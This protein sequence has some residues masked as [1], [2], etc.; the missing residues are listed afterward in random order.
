[1]SVNIVEIA[2]SK[3]QFLLKEIDDLNNF[4]QIAQVLLSENLKSTDE[5]DPIS[6]ENSIEAPEI[7][8]EDAIEPI[9]ETVMACAPSKGAAP[10][11]NAEASRIKAYL[12]ATL[13]ANS[14]LLNAMRQNLINHDEKALAE[15]A[16]GTPAE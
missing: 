16:Y 12:G 4:L 15:S 7:A 6:D 5:S 2:K 10:S 3:R 14:S 11:R 9:Q 13:A 1:M 8:A